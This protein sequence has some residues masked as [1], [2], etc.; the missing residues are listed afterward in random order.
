MMT[1]TINEVHSIHACPISSE[2]RSK[3]LD[4]I[5]LILVNHPP[6]TS[7][8]VSLNSELKPRISMLSLHEW[9]LVY[10]NFRFRITVFHQQWPLV[11]LAHVF[12]Y[13]LIRTLSMDLC[14]YATAPT[15]W[16]QVLKLTCFTSR[17]SQLIIEVKYEW[18][19]ALLISYISLHQA[20]KYPA[21]IK[22]RRVLH[23]TYNHIVAG[24]SC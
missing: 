19:S 15:I 5:M 24:F 7:R 17:N 3:P 10:F 16:Y 20:F 9:S 11:G 8:M 21:Y 12:H 4:K 13:Y 2:K 14:K 23:I 6:I 1:P 18:K 22:A